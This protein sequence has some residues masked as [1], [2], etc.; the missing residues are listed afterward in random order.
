MGGTYLVVDIDNV[1]ARTDEVMR[2][3]IKNR[4]KE[5]VNLRY[6]DVKHFNYWEC[7]DT[8]GRRITKDEWT[9]TIH[10]VFSEQANILRIEPYCEI[11]GFL[12]ELIDADYQI[13]LVT[14]RLEQARVP[15]IL[16]LDRHKIPHNALHFVKHGTKHIVFRTC[17]AIIEDDLDQARKFAEQGI[18][19]YLLA[20]PWND[21]GVA[22]NI[23]RVRDWHEIVDDLT[24]R[25]SDTR[26]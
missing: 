7:V 20:H 1:V 19:S 10:P 23:M 3:V 6:E 2:D 15:T 25:V 22:D 13:H 18:Q 9:S 4:S 26:I 17:V 12:C 5:G 24:C 21:C 14:S 11:Q 8:E 16:W